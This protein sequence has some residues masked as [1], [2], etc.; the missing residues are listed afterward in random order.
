MPISAVRG[1]GIHPGLPGMQ[2]SASEDI[3]R[4]TGAASTQRPVFPKD[5]EP[6]RRQLFT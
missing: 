3:V 6:V 2:D 4:L 1:D 5:C